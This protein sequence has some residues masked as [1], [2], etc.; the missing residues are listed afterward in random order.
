MP[1]EAG[2]VTVSRNDWLALSKHTLIAKHEIAS[3]VTVNCLPLTA[4]V[5]VV[6]KALGVAISIFNPLAGVYPVQLARVTVASKLPSTFVPLEKLN[7]TVVGN[8]LLT[9]TAELVHFCAW[10]SFIAMNA[11]IKNTHTTQRSI[12]GPGPAHKWV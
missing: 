2:E 9:K 8:I 6:S 12:F 1:D 11:P 7:G 4:W 5:P 3:L 10:L